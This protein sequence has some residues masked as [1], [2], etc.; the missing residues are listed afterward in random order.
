MKEKLREGGVYMWNGNIFEVVVIENSQ[1]FGWYLHIYDYAQKRKNKGSVS[2]EDMEYE[3]D[4]CPP[5]I[6]EL[7]D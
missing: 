3:Y 2:Q 1:S 6:K 7:M 5:V 4:I